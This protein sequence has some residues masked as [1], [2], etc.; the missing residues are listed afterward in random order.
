[1]NP[2][3]Q[4]RL[5]EL[6][7][8][9]MPKKVVESWIRTYQTSPELVITVSPFSPKFSVVIPFSVRLTKPMFAHSN[10][11]RLSPNSR[12]CP[13]ELFAVTTPAS[14]SRDH[15]VRPSFGETDRIVASLVCS[16]VH[17]FMAS[18]SD[19]VMPWSVRKWVFPL[20]HRPRLSMTSGSSHSREDCP[21][22]PYSS[23]AQDRVFPFSTV[24]L[25]L[26]V[27]DRW[28]SESVVV[29][30]ATPY[31]PSSDLATGSAPSSSCALF[32]RSSYLPTIWLKDV[33]ISAFPIL[34][35][36]SNNSSKDVSE[37]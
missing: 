2:L 28:I 37:S 26:E 14:R 25:P 29:L 3:N 15:P 12:F 32:L 10:M 24:A 35:S 11:P 20:N 36:M 16:F 8:P 33:S 30:L 7:L 6:A 18:D 19:H 21:A 34:L 1:M 13:L 9:S 23:R 22:P 17:R 5:C 31:S 27:H 4:L